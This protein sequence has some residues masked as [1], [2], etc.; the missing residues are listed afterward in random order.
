MARFLRQEHKTDEVQWQGDDISFGKDDGFTRLMF[1]N[2]NGLTLNGTD[3]LEM[4]VNDQIS[5]EIDIQGITE[6]CLDT[7]K[8]PVYQTAQEIIQ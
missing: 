1:H 3:G 5:L 6:H 7:T 8:Y 2:V 4:F